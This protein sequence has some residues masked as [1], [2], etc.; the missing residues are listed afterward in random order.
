MS[1]FST[2]NS[3]V[4]V[5]SGDAV[6]TQDVVTAITAAKPA[7]V[8]P[9]T[10]G[11]FTDGDIVLIENSGMPSL[12]NRAFIVANLDATT[13]EL[14][15]SDATNDG[16][17]NAAA[18][19]TPLVIADDMVLA[20]CNTIDF[21]PDTPATIDASTFCGTEQLIGDATPGSMSLGG[22]VDTCDPG[23]LE[24]RAAGETNAQRVVAL[25]M[26]EGRGYIVAV[27]YINAPS[28]SFAQ[29][30]A[31]SYTA[32]GVLRSKTTLCAVCV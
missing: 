10:I 27:A 8:T 28:E 4:L 5:Q 17:M 24:L 14:C 15:G 26:P 32:G 16:A 22:F 11:S 30:S 13:F 18:T 2:K 21:S 20:C 29:S 9:T 31:A 25:E 12:D 7:V 1:K 6:L 19:A 23:Y 3:R